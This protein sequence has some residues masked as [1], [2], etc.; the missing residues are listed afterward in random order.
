MN[1]PGYFQRMQ[2]RF[3]RLNADLLARRSFRMSHNDP[4]I[5]FTFDDF[6]RSAYRTGGRIL[7]KHGLA[8][9]YYLS[10]GM[11]NR[12]T[13]SGEIADRETIGNVLRDGHELGCHTYSHPDPWAVGSGQFE[14]S[15]IE[16]RRTLSDLF[17]GEA[18]KTFAYPYGVATPETKRIAGKYFICCR[19]GKQLFNSGNIDL[20]F[21]NAYFLDS[22]KKESPSSVMNIISGNRE[23]K[24]WLIFVTH[25]VAEDPSPYGCN[26]GFFDEIVRFSLDS[27]A[28]ILPVA[29]A[30]EALRNGG[31]AHATA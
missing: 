30:F 5:S 26:P 23:A 17:P 9:T 19:G 7:Q 13:D 8:G 15:I 6:P 11:L 25:D 14:S 12:T 1:T 2:N 24:G 16:N 27:G 29:R 31:R 20:N 22:R 4:M 21:L 10:M 18:F 28:V 3:R